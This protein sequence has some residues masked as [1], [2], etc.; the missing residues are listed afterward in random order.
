MTNSRNKLLDAA[1]DV[2][3]S[4]GYG[5]TRV[6]DIAAAA[7]VTKG[8]F[9]HHFPSKEACARAAAERWDRQ[10]EAVFVASGHRDCKTARERV[11]AYVDFRIALLDG[12]VW[13]YTCYVGTV[14]QETHETHPEL[15]ADCG[16]VIVRHAATLKDDLAAALEINADEARD[17][18]LHVQG[19]IQ[20]ALLLA[21]AEGGNRAA[22]ASL[23]HLKRYL[24]L[25]MQENVE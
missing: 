24:E 25:R 18:A 17:L 6:D 12:P 3:R 23:G 14:L 1:I 11:L 10:S 21:K 7:G 20:G 13:K 4:K 2:V 22:R 19:V 8:S 15:A 9:F 16:A 5:A